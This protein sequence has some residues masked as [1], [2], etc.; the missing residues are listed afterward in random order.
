MAY[1]KY[2]IFCYS[3]TIFYKY[4]FFSLLPFKFSYKIYY[5]LLWTSPLFYNLR[6]T[7]YGIG[8]RLHHIFDY[9]LPIIQKIIVGCLIAQNTDVQTIW[10]VDTVIIIIIVSVN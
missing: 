7:G 6:I 5:M 2:G 8:I 9:F 1:E 4:F 10:F 3:I